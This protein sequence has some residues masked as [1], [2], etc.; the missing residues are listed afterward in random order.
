MKATTDEQ[1]DV[2]DLRRQ[3]PA[4]TFDQLNWITGQD[5]MRGADEYKGKMVTHHE[6]YAV[7][8]AVHGWQVMR[9]FLIISKTTRKGYTLDS[10]TEVSQR[11]MMV[12]EDGSLALNIF[13]LQKAMCWQ[14][15]LQPY[16]LN[17]PLSL[18]GW[19][20][21]RTRG[22]MTMFFLTDEYIYPV[23]DFSR[24][25]EETGLAKV[26]GRWDEIELYKDRDEALREIK[27]MDLDETQ[28]KPMTEK[29]YLPTIIETLFKIGE[30]GLA[31]MM[32]MHDG[33]T[34][35]QISK[36]WLSFLCARRHGLRLDI[37]G[38]IQW[39]DYV[40]D[41]DKLGRDI[42][43]PKYLIPEDIGRAHA[44]ILPRVQ[45]IRRREYEERMRARNEAYRL[46]LEREEQRRIEEAKKEEAGYQKRM[47][48]Y[49]GIVIVTESGLTITP[50]QSVQAFKEE[51]DAM[52]H[53]VFHN[54]YYRAERHCLILSARDKDG[55]RV[56]TIR[57]D[58]NT[59]TVAESRG[60]C[61]KATEYHD[62]IVK[63]M[64]SNM[65]M[66]EEI[67]MAA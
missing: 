51:G 37:N 61:N 58:L 18:K 22:S 12:R 6:Y 14:Y 63:A 49:F 46:R 8:T 55:K 60:V 34:K 45:E 35:Q 17:A 67:R 15:H 23:R 16:C 31:R 39:L 5:R 42:R 59:F 13:E 47:Q 41:L 9:Y 65:K 38:W 36:Y 44:S 56:E 11:W 26:A 2:L 24:S 10:I 7:V 66:I 3:L 52:H 29:C 19:D 57:I 27:S 54:G 33:I 21:G 64:Q 28:V 32:I 20:T 62:E 1:K 48:V 40:T 25:F 50:L 53:C 4:L 43:S 30:E